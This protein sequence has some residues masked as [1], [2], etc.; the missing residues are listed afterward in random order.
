MGALLASLAEFM[1]RKAAFVVS[2][3]A[4]MGPFRWWFRRRWPRERVAGALNVALRPHR[5]RQEWPN[6]PLYY[7]LLPGDFFVGIEVEANLWFPITVH[8]VSVSGRLKDI[9]AGTAAA[10]DDVASLPSEVSAAS[11]RW[12]CEFHTDMRPGALAL[13]RSQHL[14]EL[15]DASV[16][17]SLTVSFPWHEKWAIDRTIPVIAVVAR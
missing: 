12:A 4:A 13:L 10:P 3:G 6:A 2:M 8:S 5:Q 1:V 11:S 15:C 17:V 7:S 14:S 9:V 16:Q